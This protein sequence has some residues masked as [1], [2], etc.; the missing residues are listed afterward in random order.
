MIT[1]FK[2]NLPMPRR[3][4]IQF[5]DLNP[6]QQRLL[7]IKPVRNELVNYKKENDII[8]LTYPKNFT[9][10]ERFLHRHIGGPMVIRRPLDEKGTMI[11]EL[12]DGEHT[13]HDICNET[14]KAFKEDI[15]PV[16]T[17]VWG[18]LQTLL[19]LGLISLESDE[20][21]QEESD[22]K[23]EEKEEKEEAEEGPA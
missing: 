18:F 16:L 22:D 19:T 3:H 9:R 8:V 5:D 17:R 23:D 15:E 20:M 2:V 10:F 11:W 14:Y 12:C 7:M 21:E 4:P 6:E 1:V 13:V